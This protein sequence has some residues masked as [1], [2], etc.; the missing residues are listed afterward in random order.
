M[1]IGLVRR[2]GEIKSN[3]SE[4]IILETAI[5]NQKPYKQKEFFAVDVNLEDGQYKIHLEEYDSNKE[6]LYL[7]GI[8]GGHSENLSPVLN[9]KPKEKEKEKILNIS[10]FPSENTLFRKYGL[11]REEFPIYTNLIRWFENKKEN[12]QEDIQSLITQNYINEKT[13]KIGNNAPTMVVFK[14]LKDGDHCYPGEIDEFVQAY[15]H[16]NTPP[17]PK[18]SQ[19]GTCM[20]CGQ[21]KPLTTTK[22]IKTDLFEFFSLDLNNF[23]IGM[24]NSKT[25]QLTL[26][27]DCQDL[28]KLGLSVLDNELKF[29][30]YTKKIDSKKTLFV[31]HSLLPTA[32]GEQLVIQVINNL[33]KIRREKSE[34]ERQSIRK[35][36]EEIQQR[37]E[38]ANKK[39]IRKLK[40]ELKKKEETFGKIKDFAQ[41]DEREVL[42][43]FAEKGVSYVDLYY[44]N[45]SVG[46]GNSKKV[47]MDM[48]FVNAKTLKELLTQ[49]DR[50]EQEFASKNLLVWKGKPYR[51]E[52]GKLYSLFTIKM[53]DLVRKALLTRITVKER[54]LARDALKSLR[55]PFLKLNAEIDKNI[56]ISREEYHQRLSTFL[57]VD[58][59]LNSLNLLKEK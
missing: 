55:D 5:K 39:A 36:I 20:A 37:M 45:E 12:I 58:Q 2:L 48:T 29:R 59:L 52:F 49:I 25:W 51:F 24:D 9:V 33:K 38:R 26:C 17:K 11:K 18:K 42:K 46:V 1:L 6:L 54:E 13:K 4:R 50:I 16:M 3:Q 14:V 28:V 44:I 32:Y 31:D 40:S 53:A 21:K 43:Q 41:I 30:A 57:F 56:W 8:K 7:R 27:L 22:D 23:I 35:E 19:I 34:E 10:K 15:L 47:F